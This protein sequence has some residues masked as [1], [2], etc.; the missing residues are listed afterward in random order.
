MKLKYNILFNVSKC[1]DYPSEV[2]KMLWKLPQVRLLPFY[3]PNFLSIL[4]QASEIEDMNLLATVIG[5]LQTPVVK[6]WFN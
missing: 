6:R 1:I 5:S 4:P 3:L 2:R